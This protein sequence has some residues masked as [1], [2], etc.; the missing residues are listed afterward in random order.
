MPEE[1]KKLLKTYK[2]FRQKTGHQIE[3]GDINY[4]GGWCPA[5]GDQGPYGDLSYE[6]HSCA[7]EYSEPTT[8]FPGPTTFGML[9]M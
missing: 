9:T 1:K 5:D 6:L 8:T 7:G 3:Y 2:H 4:I